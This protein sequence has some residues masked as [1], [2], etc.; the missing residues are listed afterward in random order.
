MISIVIPTYKRLTALQRC[1]DSI[2]PQAFDGLEVIVIDD[3]SLDETESY[4]RQ[5]A[6]RFAFIRVIVNQQNGGVNYSRNRGIEK[7]TGKFILF[8]DS[9]DELMPG[10][11]LKVK[12]TLETF[13]D[14]KHFLF[15][16]SDR[17]EEFRSLERV[18]DIAYE[19]WL[20][21]TTSGDYTHVVLASVMKKY[22]FFEEF[23]MFEYLNWLR[24]KKETGPQ[25]L[26]PIV[27]ALRERD[28]SDSLTLNS[29]LQSVAVIRSKFESEKMFYSMYHE[30]LTKYNPDSLNLKLV[31]TMV[32]GAACDQKRASRSLLSYAN[33]AHIK[34]LGSLLMLIPSSLLQY[35]IIKYSTLKKR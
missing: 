2:L 18:K 7:A 11:L 23:R 5:L 24:I 29:R 28:R 21:G 10:S 22:L 34:I 33:K 14:R 32:L 27:V 25:L 3:C 26:V 35:G 20:N 9:D 15:I 12:Q 8:L 6:G 30:D 19:T 17:E 31:H 4:L 16:V 1:I 13:P